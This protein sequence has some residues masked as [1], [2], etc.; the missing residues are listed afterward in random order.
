[1]RKNILIAI[2]MMV[3]VSMG[4]MGTAQ[5]MISEPDVVFYGSAATGSVGSMITILLNGAA[6]P[7]ASCIVGADLKYVL[8]VPISL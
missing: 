1:M 4:M 3:A 7:V 6:T 2:V 5:A 8:R